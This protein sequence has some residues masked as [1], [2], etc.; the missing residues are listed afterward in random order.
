MDTAPVKLTRTQREL[1][2]L[3]CAGQVTRNFPRRGPM[4][5]RREDTGKRVTSQVGRLL[6]LK[7]VDVPSRPLG[8]FGPVIVQLTDRGA[9][10]HA[11][12]S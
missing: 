12:Q 10:A 3:V 7:L 5:Y 4:F 1:L 6:E 2:D 9:A 11:T 8:T